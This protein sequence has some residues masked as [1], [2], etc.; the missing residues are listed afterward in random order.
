[1]VSCKVTPTICVGTYL[2]VHVQCFTL[3]NLCTYIDP[4]HCLPQPLHM[5]A[6]ALNAFSNIRLRHIQNDADWSITVYNHPL[7]KSPETEVC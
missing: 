2:C 5:V 4:V 6:A 1:M 7:P 3:R